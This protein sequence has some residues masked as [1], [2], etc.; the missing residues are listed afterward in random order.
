[1][2]KM[3][4]LCNNPSCK[5]ALS[6]KVFEVESLSSPCPVCGESDLLPES[7]S[8]YIDSRDHHNSKKLHENKAKIREKHGRIHGSSDD[9]A[10]LK[11]IELSY[12]KK[13]AEMEKV[14]KN[15]RL[16]KKFKDIDTHLTDS[17][18]ELKDIKYELEK[19]DRLFKSYREDGKSKKTL[20]STRKTAQSSKNGK[21]KKT[22]NATASK[23]ATDRK[24]SSSEKKK[25][26]AVSKKRS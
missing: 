25:T 14:M 17:D 26:P 18:L 11:K 3:K 24:R 6:K 13:M 4:A 8:K 15:S 19:L 7:A 5:N 16:M 2:R 1:M 12:S 10:E 20:T 23:S 9:S 22:D 21:N